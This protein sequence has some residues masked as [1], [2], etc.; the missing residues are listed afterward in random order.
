MDA[1]IDAAEPA[2]VA[3][4][5]ARFG[6][7]SVTPLGGRASLMPVSPPS[8]LA[9]PASRP[10]PIPPHLVAPRCFYLSHKLDRVWIAVEFLDTGTNTF[11]EIAQVAQPC[12]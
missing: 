6:E 7:A 11:D 9:A 4:Q 8:T 10:A 2:G 12:D 3:G 5:G 1:E